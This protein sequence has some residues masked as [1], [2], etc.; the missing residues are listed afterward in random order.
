MSERQGRCLCGDVT[1]RVSA[2]PLV[3]RICWC[4]DC[5]H[6][7]ANGTA[8]MLV[9]SEALAITG[10][11]HEFAS[12]AESGNMIRRRFCPRCGVHLFA[13]ADVRPKFTVVRVGTL[14]DPST[15]KPSINIWVGSAPTWACVDRQLE[16]V[17]RQ[18]AP[19]VAPTA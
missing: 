3:T 19:P 18:P 11:T 10:A 13:N 4:R 9:L 12:R 7:S 1:Y 8:N 5:Q 17:D 2:E 16:C 6:L 14:D 15:A